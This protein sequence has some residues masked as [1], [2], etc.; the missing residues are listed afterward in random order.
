MSDSEP[1]M[2]IVGNDDPLRFLDPSLIRLLALQRLNQL[3]RNVSQV[4][5]V[6]IDNVLEDF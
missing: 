6:I 5:V 3:Q 4:S 1:Q 2:D